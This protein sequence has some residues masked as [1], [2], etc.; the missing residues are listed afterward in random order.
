MPAQPDIHHPPAP[1]SND[2][3][4]WIV[5][6]DLG[7]RS[8]GAL[9]VA[10]WLGGGSDHV[11]GVYVLETWSRPYLAAD[12][13]TTVHHA[14]GC[15]AAQQRVPPPARVSVIEANLA[16]EGLARAAEGAAG[17][18]IGRAAR[19]NDAPFVRLGHVARK[20]LRMLPGPV[21]VVPRDL[22]AV[23]PGPIVLATDLGDATTAALPFAQRLAARHGRPLELVHVGEPRNSDLI[24]E[25]EPSWLAARE[26]YRAQVERAF[27]V[28]MHD[29][30]LQ[31]VARHVA[32]GD[33]ATKV[34]EF[35]A[36]RH[37]ALVVVG[38]RR[39][40]TAARVFLSS[41][42]STLAGAAA[43]PVAVVPP[44]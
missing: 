38:S 17:L 41:S 18:V 34:A 30:H 8:L 9:V 32:Y 14:V 22:T 3:R 15:A 24:D 11:V 25:L 27:D 39:L 23:P 37:A 4:S 7:E 6:L 42:A 26:E 21:V 2:D 13:I 44:A 20:L 40:G 29:N 36:A 1:T 16:E 12:I 10:D 31:R 33:V 19:A 5:G 35:A 28:W 43:C